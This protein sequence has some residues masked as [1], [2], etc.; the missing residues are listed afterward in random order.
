MR[1][2]LI[3]SLGTASPAFSWF[4]KDHAKNE[5]FCQA[6]EQQKAKEVVMVCNMAGC[7]EAVRGR[8]RLID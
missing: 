8:R 2:T 4:V 3:P 5:L 7:L 1:M 6:V